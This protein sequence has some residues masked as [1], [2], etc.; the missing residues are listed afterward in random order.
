[1]AIRNWPPEDWKDVYEKYHE[2]G[3]WYSGSPEQLLKY[4]SQ[5]AKPFWAKEVKE[6]RQTM[7]H[8]PVAGDIAGVS[9]DL[10]LSESPEIKIPEA[11]QEN[12][13]TDAIETQNRLDEIINNTDL[14]GRLLEAAET[15]SS[16]SGVFLKVNWDTNFKDYPI[17]SVAQP[18]NAIPEFRFGFLQR[19]TFHKVIDAPNMNNYWRHLE[20]HEPGLIR[21]EL[22]RG[23]RNSLGERLALTAHNKTSEMEP[24]I[25]TGLDT[26]A[27][28]YIPNKK[29]NRLWRGSSLGQSDLS[30]IEGIMD[31]IDETYTSWVRDLRLARARMIVP[32]YMLELDDGK[33][34]FDIDKQI[35]TALN[36]GPPG[37]GEIKEVQFDIR[38]E[39]HRD[40]AH[41]LYE[42][43]V[44]MAGYSPQSFGLEGESYSSATATEVKAKEGKSFKTRNKKA[45][46]IKGALE[47]TLWIALQ[48]DNIHFG[49]NVNP[50]YRPQVN[51]QDSVITDPMEKAD[52]I[53]KLN[54]AEAMS[55]DTKVRSLHENWTEEQ[56]QAEVKRI[57]E[58]KGIMVE[59]PI[60]MEMS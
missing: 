8:V 4:Y 3:A 59:D 49:N 36:Q 34:K 47:E 51:L 41:E 24:E 35:F 32:E 54:Q 43:A 22:Y 23:T 1:L 55:I 58:E 56:I 60:D 44:S 9:A 27:C 11:H 28:R 5:K 13:P 14:Y 26:L 40:T 15:A 30:G 18:D 33:F 20:I 16:M 25:N 10:L 57:M 45:R 38:A 2:W 53:N 46:Y 29:P 48:I 37:A 7:L 12:A 19:V 17:I 39:K 42:K 31:S 21:N 52:S 50:D 6:D